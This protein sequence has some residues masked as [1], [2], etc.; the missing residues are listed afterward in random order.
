MKKYY[1]LIIMSICGIFSLPMLSAQ[2]G[3]KVLSSDKIEEWCYRLKINN[4]G[5]RSEGWHGILSK[6]GKPIE[7]AKEGEVIETPMGKFKW[8]GKPDTKDTLF[9][10]RGWLNKLPRGKNVF[11]PIQNSK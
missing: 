5:T 11:E 9:R 1:V 8:F 10:N 3:E 2:Q 7:G 4:K 6:N